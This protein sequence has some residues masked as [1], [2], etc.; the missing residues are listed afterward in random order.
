MFIKKNPNL[1]SLFW[2]WVGIF[3][4]NSQPLWANCLV[5]SEVVVPHMPPEREDRAGFCYAYAA[6]QLLQQFYCST[7]KDGCGFAQGRTDDMLSVLDTISQYSAVV[8]PPHEGGSAIR[9]LEALSQNGAIAKESCAPLDSTLGIADLPHYDPKAADG[10]WMT[11]LQKNNQHMQE[12]IRKPQQGPQQKQEGLVC[13]YDKDTQTGSTAQA[14]A[15]ALMPTLTDLPSSTI[16]E[17]F[18][19][20]KTGC[21]EK[22]IQ[23][24]PFHSEAE[25][26]IQDDKAYIDA[27]SGIISNHQRPAQIDVCLNPKADKLESCLGHVTTVSGAREKC[28]DGTCT[29]EFRLTDS[30]KRVWVHSD[31]D[32]WVSE[33]DL[34]THTDLFKKSKSRSLVWIETGKGNPDIGFSFRTPKAKGDPATISGISEQSPEYVAGIRNGMNY[35]KHEFDSK[36]GEMVVWIITNTGKPREYRYKLKP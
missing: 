22:R 34:L 17:K 24:E 30:M 13:G 35:G 25:R 32:G 21:G 14:L 31:A 4:T 29:K 11:L 26:N 36:T 27:L 1:V 2:L 7:K 16:I 18:I 28:C 10:S 19:F 9:V 5:K 33:R 23:L 3:S 20:P 6:T 12:R 8:Q 15:T